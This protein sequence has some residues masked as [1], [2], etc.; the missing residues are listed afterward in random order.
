[1]GS[2]GSEDSPPASPPI[3][4]DPAD[5]R[6]APATRYLLQALLVGTLA[7]L[8][9][10]WILAYLAPMPYFLSLFFFM[11]LGL[12]VGAVMCRAARPGT[13]IA[14][15]RSRPVSLFVSLVICLG[16]IVW[17]NR[18]FPDMAARKAVQLS[19]V[20]KMNAQELNAYRERV[21]RAARDQL[22]SRYWP[23]GVLG[24]IRWAATS[25]RME[26]PRAGSDE[27]VP[28]ENVQLPVKWIIRVVASLALLMFAIDS[29]M[30]SLAP[31]R[32]LEEEAEDQ[33]EDRKP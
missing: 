4:A 8:P 10:A 19:L 5:A 30:A 31:R 14:R 20:S 25:G 18:W 12:L 3:E 6:A 7:G 17:E 24:Y 28:L 33:G 32:L 9:A 16:V 11:L 2:N 13:P 21:R 1:M 26:F 29:Q 27:P 22:S 15:D 23:G